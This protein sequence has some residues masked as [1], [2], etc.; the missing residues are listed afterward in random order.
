MEKRGLVGHGTGVKASA[1]KIEMKRAGRWRALPS[2]EGEAGHGREAWGRGQGT[3]AWELGRKQVR[4]ELKGGGD[5][6][7]LAMNSQ[8][9]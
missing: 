7:T 2:E 3:C 5:P 6:H 4:L 9:H 1:K 8:K